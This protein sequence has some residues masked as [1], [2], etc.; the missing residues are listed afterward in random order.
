[1]A[2]T[3][4]TSGAKG[5]ASSTDRGGNGVAAPDPAPAPSGQQAPVG[6]LSAMWHYRGMCIVIVVVCTALSAVLGLVLT[7]EPSAT[8]TIALKTPGE[9]NVLSP[10][11]TGDASLARYTAQRARFVT[12]DAVLGN[13]AAAMDTDDLNDL[14]SQLEVT[15][16]TDSNIITISAS[17]SSGDDAVELAT[18]VTRAYAEETQKQVN[19][20]TDAALKSIDESAA[21]VRATIT[22]NNTAV[23]DAAA[24]TLGQLQQRQA[25]VRTSSAV[26]GD[27]VEFVVNPDDSSVAGS[28]LPV[29]EIGLGFILGL[30]I[31]GTAAYLRADSEA[32]AERAA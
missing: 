11:L 22:S 27:G 20:L 21:S 24:S 30:V 15:P 17:G 3:S 19:A 18:E 8:A 13:V 5:S 7:P 6:L 4:R 28:K 14:R 23:N 32:A 10:G 1:M 29:K 12:S 25:A 9:D 2:E 26:L 16:S 31:A